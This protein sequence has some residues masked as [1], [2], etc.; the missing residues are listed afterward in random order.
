M[1]HNPYSG[2]EKTASSDMPQLLA[3]MLA[4]L[5]VRNQLVDGYR[6]SNSHMLAACRRINFS[7]ETLR[8]NV[9]PLVSRNLKENLKICLKNQISLESSTKKTLIYYIFCLLLGIQFIWV[10]NWKSL[11][12]KTLLGAR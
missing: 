8:D 4:L 6:E 9:C 12:T 3:C 2:A 11:L 10:V 7:G 1:R 5:Q